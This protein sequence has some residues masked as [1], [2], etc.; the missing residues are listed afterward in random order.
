MDHGSQTHRAPVADTAKN[1]WPGFQIIENVLTYSYLFSESPQKS[2]PKKGA[3]R[4][5][6]PTATS[7]EKKAKKTKNV[8]KEVKP[9]PKIKVQTKSKTKKTKKEVPSEAVSGDQSMEEEEE[10]DGISDSELNFLKLEKGDSPVKKSRRR[11]A[12]KNE[13]DDVSFCYSRNFQQICSFSGLNFL[14][15]FFR[16]PRK[17]NQVLKRKIKR[18]RTQR[19][20]TKSEVRKKKPLYPKKPGNQILKRKIQK[21]NLVVPKNLRTVQTQVLLKNQTRKALLKLRKKNHHLRMSLKKKL[22]N[23]VRNPKKRPAHPVPL[24]RSI[25]L[26]P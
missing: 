23:K 8:D 5:S 24:K 20:R 22:Q 7:N 19:P 10:G 25:L 1:A 3:K 12:A 18:S 17:L 13:D 9:S 4:K 6:S 15:F 2:E 14:N 16:I 26:Q 11:S 21:R